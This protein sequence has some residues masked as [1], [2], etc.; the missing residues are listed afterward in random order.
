MTIG[1]T[2][3]SSRLNRSL[4]TEK[5]KAPKGAP[6]FLPVDTVSEN[7]NQ[8]ER[9]VFDAYELIKNANLSNYAMEMRAAGTT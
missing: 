5:T 2:T 3:F 9:Y 8:L 6:M 4:S 7:W 1:Q